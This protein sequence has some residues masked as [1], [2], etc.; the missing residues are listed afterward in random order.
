M[1]VVLFGAQSVSCILPSLLVVTSL[2]RAQ[3]CWREKKAG[4]LNDNMALQLHKENLF[5]KKPTLFHKTVLVV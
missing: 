1:S 5:K 2:T 4:L 3:A